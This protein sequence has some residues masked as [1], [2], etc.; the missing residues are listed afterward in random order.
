MPRYRRARIPPL[1]NIVERTRGF[2]QGLFATTV[3][4]FIADPPCF[5]APKN[6]FTALGV[7]C[8]RL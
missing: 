6:L 8:A 2:A 7:A 5:T 3:V 4:I 1:H